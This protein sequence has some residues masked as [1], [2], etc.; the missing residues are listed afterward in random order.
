MCEFPTSI[1]SLVE[2]EFLEIIM[3]GC[4]TLKLNRQTHSTAIVTLNDLFSISDSEFVSQ[5]RTFD[6]QLR[7][8]TNTVLCYE[9]LN[10]K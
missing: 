7:S 2:K 6:S 10:I 8:D 1:V 4:K 9:R 3:R 5:L